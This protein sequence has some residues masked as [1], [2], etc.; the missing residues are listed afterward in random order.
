MAVINLKV[1]N[2]KINYIVK[3]RV[4]KFL[5]KLE[6]EFMNVQTRKSKQKP[7]LKDE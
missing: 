6:H 2:I 3:I 7:N 4:I 1:E 5:V